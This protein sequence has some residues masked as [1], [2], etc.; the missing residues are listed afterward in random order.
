MHTFS[1]ATRLV[2]VAIALGLALP[3]GVAT[4]M[5]PNFLFVIA[6]DQSPMDLRVYDPTTRLETPNIDRLAAQGMTLDGAHHMGAFIGGVCTPSRHMIMSGR[7]L[8]HLPASL[9]SRLFAN[10]PAGLC[11]PG[12]EQH[13]IPA[14]FNSAGYDT[15]RTCKIGNSYEA[16][17]TLFT[18]RK[19]RSN[20]GPSDDKGSAWHADQVLDF[21]SQRAATGA[22]PASNPVRGR[23]EI[24]TFLIRLRPS[25]TWPAF[26]RRPRMRASVSGRSSKANAPPCAMSSMVCTAAAPNPACA[27]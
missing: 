26:P 2:L 21:L 7:T 10:Y 15:M 20:Y 14:V 25:A 18:V 16:A 24:S 5:R 17:N 27:A 8:W 12:L 4:A 6:D 22:V 23:R 11:P 3:L 1:S 19:D 9:T 13:T